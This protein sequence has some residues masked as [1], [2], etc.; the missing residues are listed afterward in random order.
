MQ[1]YEINICEIMIFKLYT[2]YNKH[3][4]DENWRL[5]QRK[6]ASIIASA[7]IILLLIVPTKTDRIEDV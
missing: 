5:S 1:F 4:D 2:V 6:I 3:D 7:R